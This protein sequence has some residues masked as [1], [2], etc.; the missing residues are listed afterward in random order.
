[1]TIAHLLE[2]FGPAASAE[3]LKQMVTEDALE[4]L[5]LGAFEEG[6]SAGWDDAVSAQGKDRLRVGESLSNSLEDLSFTYQEAHSQ[7]TAEL[8]PLFGC[9]TKKVLP[10]A[11]AK[12]FGQ[13]VVDALKEM[14][15]N[16]LDQPAVLLVP[17]GAADLVET[18][19]DQDFSMPV[20]LRED[21][22]LDSGQAYIRVG[23][24]ERELNSDR[25]LSTMSEL[26]EAYIFQ[27]K[28]EK[29]HG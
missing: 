18:A 24:A 12:T 6:Y 10:D 16:Q 14:A 8:D 29:W 15:K 27:A 3:G 17:P 2:D 25:L 13:H 9:L 22:S 26:I 19:L 21:P 20:E 11:M 28:E 1:M 23:G 5:Q 4:D 7:L